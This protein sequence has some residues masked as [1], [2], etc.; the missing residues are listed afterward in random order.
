[1]A[2]K[3]LIDTPLNEIIL[4]KYEKSEINN[5]REIV[6]RLCLSL[7]ILQPGDSRDIIVDIFYILLQAKKENKYLTSEE[8]KEKVIEF[9]KINKL[10]L[11]GLASSNVR[12]QLKRLRDLFLVEKIKNN[13]RITEFNNISEIFQDKIIQFL[14]PNIIS[15]IKEYINQTD[16]F[17]N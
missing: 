7:G 8:V 12:R 3:T 17:F 16:S 10:S 5:K 4:R 11:N 9:R 6:K 15:R 1:M 2:K 13:Y 14:L